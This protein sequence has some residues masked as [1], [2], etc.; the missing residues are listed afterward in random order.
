M[1]FSEADSFALKEKKRDPG[2]SKEL[3]EK[4]SGTSVFKQESPLLARE[5]AL[6]SAIKREYPPG[7]ITDSLSP[8]KVTPGLLTE[9]F[10]QKN[11]FYYLELDSTNNLAKVL[12]SKEYP[13]GTVVVAE[14]QTAGRGR[15]GRNWYSPAKQGIY[16]SVILRPL[17]PLREI[18]RI[19]L[20]AGVAVAETLTERMNLQPCIKWPN[21]ILINQRKIAGILSEVVSRMNSIEYLVL[22]IGL[23]INNHIEDFPEDFVTSPTSALAESKCSYSRSKI[24]QGLLSRLE[25]HYQQM[26]AGNFYHTLE[27]AKS[28]SIVIGK[29]VRLDT[30]NGVVAGQAIDLD[31]NGFLLVRDQLGV[32]NRVMSGEIFL[33]P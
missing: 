14:M 4:E 20:L 24:L 1:D 21:D 33:L 22:G 8:E 25:Y 9:V 11:Y 27:K 5:Y 16:L 7:T 19:S 30:I 28:M 10:G 26:L 2:S 32:I 23:N 3:I 13:E 29:E 12:A 15:R 17:I 6:E 31:D 18:S